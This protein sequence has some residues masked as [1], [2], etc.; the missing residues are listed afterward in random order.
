LINNDVT[1]ALNVNMKKQNH[2]QS[3]GNKS[4]SPA[5]KNTGTTTFPLMPHTT[6]EACTSS[7]GALEAIRARAY[8]LFELRGQEPGHAMDDWLQA[9]RE[10][11][12][13]SPTAVVTSA[14]LNQESLR[15]HER[16]ENDI[17]QRQ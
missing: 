7:N 4:E 8:R 2:R 9:E 3:N 10:I 13:P 1:G 11:L 6:A 17:S 15:P 12:R 5:L 16:R 14:V